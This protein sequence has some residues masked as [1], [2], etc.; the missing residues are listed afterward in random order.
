M[1]KQK[2][3]VF[4]ISNMSLS[5][6]H[7]SL[8]PTNG[9]TQR[10][11]SPP[12]AHEA[13]ITTQGGKGRQHFTENRL[14]KWHAWSD[15]RCISADGAWVRLVAAA[16]IMVSRKHTTVDENTLH[17]RALAWWEWTRCI[18]M[19]LKPSH[20]AVSVNLEKQD[21]GENVTF[22]KVN[23]HT[24]QQT[25]AKGEENSSC[26][27]VISPFALFGLSTRV[28]R[29]WMLSYTFFWTARISRDEPRKGRR[30]NEQAAH[31]G[32]GM[33]WLA[34]DYLSLGWGWADGLFT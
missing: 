32:S 16:A 17:P 24:W 8:S 29:N 25:A 13:F 9:G 3:W 10:L 33:V 1:T 22:V 30:G 34:R 15:Y 27:L 26:A 21:G 31:L 18:A 4:P 23:K 6:H 12:E 28:K 2:C 7:L 19:Y 5:I 11:L 20:E 14:E